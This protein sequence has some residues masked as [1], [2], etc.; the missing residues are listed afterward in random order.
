MIP[1][2]LMEKPMTGP[3][4]QQPGVVPQVLTRRVAFHYELGTFGI[5]NRART[6]Q[7]ARHAVGEVVEALRRSG[8]LRPG[9]AAVARLRLDHPQASLAELGAL[10]DPP[11]T[12][13]TVAGRLRRL[14][15]A[16]RAPHKP[17]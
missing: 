12:K 16:A 6:A 5:A 4:E 15:Q 3:W 7:A 14:R 1:E 10:A 13:D 11:L 8:G 2:R 9:V 17:V